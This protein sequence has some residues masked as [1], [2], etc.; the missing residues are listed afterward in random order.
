[1]WTSPTCGQTELHLGQGRRRAGSARHR[2]HADVHHRRQ[3]EHRRGELL[4]PA[5]DT[6]ATATVNDVHPL[7]A[8]VDAGG[9]N[10]EVVYGFTPPTSGTWVFRESTASDVVFVEPWSSAGGIRVSVN[11]H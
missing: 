8:C 9:R 10:G 11:T 5:N 3:R 1:M 4:S 6:F 2:G 7:A